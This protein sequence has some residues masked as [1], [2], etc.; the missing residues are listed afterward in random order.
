M[1]RTLFASFRIKR[2]LSLL[3]FLAT[4]LGLAALLVV[5]LAAF[6]RFEARRSRVEMHTEPARN[7]ISRAI[8][9]AGKARTLVH[10]HAVLGARTPHTGFPSALSA[11]RSL[12]AQW[13]RHV[14]READIRF[15]GQAVVE[16]W[17]EGL[18]A[19][20]AWLH[21]YGMQALARPSGPDP[22]RAVEASALFE[23]G[24]LALER[25][26]SQVDETRSRLLRGSVNSNEGQLTMVL[27]LGML[28][29]L[30]AILA[31]WNLQRLDSLGMRERQA[32]EQLGVA[33][34]EIHHRVKNNLQ[35]VNALL[36]MKLMDA[37]ADTARAALQAIAQQLRVVTSVHDFTGT[38]TR[39]DVVRARRVLD[40]L[41]AM[42]AGPGL[43]V[44]VE[45]DDCLLTLGEATSVGLLVNELL[46]R[47][48]E[49]GESAAGVRLV[50]DDGLGRA[51]VRVCHGALAAE[52]D[53][54]A[55]QPEALS[56]MLV[57]TLATHD[58][59]GEIRF[60]DGELPCVEVAFRTMAPRT[61]ARQ[62]RG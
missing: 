2:S 10:L 7:Q 33:V 20:R 25:A 50:R 46:V 59:H 48:A 27:S 61:L 13:D 39:A 44:D 34:R 62:M 24:T 29:T 47:A 30:L 5:P 41:A 9:T 35:V 42:H 43:R 28:C 53:V 37:G 14:A 54:G 31:G 56:A 23:Q 8:E 26:R 17:R 4:L 52:A 51:V 6:Y 45:A 11:Y 22:E 38:E 18:A 16:P 58:L 21:G 12:V 1:R 15:C 55:S 36:D 49:A 32:Q 19:L 3:V 57:R 60:L 40:R